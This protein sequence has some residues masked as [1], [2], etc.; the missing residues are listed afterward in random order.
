MLRFSPSDPGVQ[1]AVAR[2][3]AKCVP[4]AKHCSGSSKRMVND[5]GACADRSPQ[6]ALQAIQT[7]DGRADAGAGVQWIAVMPKTRA[8]M[9]ASRPATRGQFKTGHI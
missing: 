1:V 2:L 7:A 8:S 5:V 3:L 9:H 6:V 4:G